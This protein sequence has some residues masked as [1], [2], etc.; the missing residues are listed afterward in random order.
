MA[1]DRGLHCFLR[2][3]CPITYGGKYGIFTHLTV[4]SHKRDIGKQ[5]GP[6]SDAVERGVQTGSTLFALDAG[7]SIKLDKTR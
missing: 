6:R 3:I 1:S 7:I 5:C 2:L 4:A